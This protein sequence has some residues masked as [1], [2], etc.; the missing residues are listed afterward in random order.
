MQ[1]FF[2]TTLVSK[3]IKYLL[4]V[5]PLPIC[6]YLSDTD[7]MV[8]GGYYVYQEKVYKCTKTGLFRGSYKTFN[9]PLCCS[10]TV[11]CGGHYVDELDGNKLKPLTVTDKHIAFSGSRMAEYQVVN[12]I[13][14]GVP[15]H[16]MTEYFVSTRTDY[17]SDTHKKL[18]DYLRFL[19][20][21]YGL[22]LMP[23]YNCFS[24]YYVKGVDLSKGVLLED[25]VTDYKTALVPVKFNR[26]YT[27]ALNSSSTVFI[28]PVLYDGKLI[29][30]YKNTDKYIC[31]NGQLGIR[32][33]NFLRYNF[34]VTIDVSN[35]DSELQPLEKNLYLAI[36]M[37]MSVKPPI[38]VIEGEYGANGNLKIYDES[39]FRC[40][41]NKF[42]DNI[43]TSELSLLNMPTTLVRSMDNVPF[44]DKLISYLLMHTIDPREIIDENVKRVTDKFGYKAG[45]EGS[46]GPEIRGKLFDSYMMLSKNRDELN[47]TDILGY[48]D[49]DIERALSR[50][51][52]TYSE[53]KKMKTIT[54]EVK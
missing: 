46:W 13:E 41:S 23:L 36:Q 1:K 34:P 15:L 25:D 8:E 47:Y 16:G 9:G 35:T 21:Q 3:F 22:N 44:S 28:K 10:N 39:M 48:V 24:E 42:V 54:A 29:R 5:T 52:L 43:L 49:A 31:D 12:L 30:D 17:D 32:K 7:T 45:Y 53:S 50:G 38:V 40:S 37:P 51:W 26:K 18:G 6:S 11:Y 4:M 20:S 2:S 14:E 19:N 27:V 33:F